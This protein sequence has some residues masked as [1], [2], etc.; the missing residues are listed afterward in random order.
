MEKI[1][2]IIMVFSIST[3]LL[4][5]L[6]CWLIWV[7][8][9]KGETREEILVPIYLAQF[10]VCK[11]LHRIIS[12]EIF[13]KI[14][15]QEKLDKL[16]EICGRKTDVQKINFLFK[17]TES[18]PV[19]LKEDYELELKSWFDFFLRHGWERY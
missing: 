2:M 6:G 18:T 8:F 10:E 4:I 15:S 12:S 11:N 9:F 1:E 14:D 16:F 3:T 19:K 7:R 13:K 5:E 17:I